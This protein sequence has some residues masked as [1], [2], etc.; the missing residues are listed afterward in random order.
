[1]FNKHRLA[2]EMSSVMLGCYA[3][4]DFVAR[5]K[6][7][8]CQCVFVRWRVQGMDE[9]P[10]GIAIVLASCGGPRG[11]VAWVG[12]REVFGCECTYTVEK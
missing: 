11:V 5:E 4:N 1:M 6:N 9:K 3:G 12:V 7:S 2:K 10:Q 8:G